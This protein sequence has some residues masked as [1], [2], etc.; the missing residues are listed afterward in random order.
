[1]EAPLTPLDPALLFPSAPEALLACLGVA[2]GPTS[3][4]L[5]AAAFSEY[6]QDEIQAQILAG[7]ERDV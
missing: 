6:D 5:S 4:R 3:A 7:T 2:S 1:M